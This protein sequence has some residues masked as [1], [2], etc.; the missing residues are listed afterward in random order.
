MGSESKFKAVPFDLG[1]TLVK[2]ADISEIFR[3]ILEIYGVRASI[4]DI[5]KA[6]QKNE[7]EL[8]VK[9]MVESGSG[10]WIKWNQKMLKRLRVQGDVEFL[11][12]QIDALWWDHADLEVYPEVSETLVQLERKEV[13]SGIVTNSFEKDFQ[14]ILQKLGL[15]DHF[16]VVVGIDTCKSAK[17]DREIFL[18]AVN[19]LDVR[20]EEAL[21]VGDSIQYDSEGA[22]A[23][24]LKP[25]LVDRNNKAIM[26]AQT[27]RSLAEVLAYV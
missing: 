24:G 3:R 13:K 16:D 2:T 21:F 6:Y 7:R 20:P 10:Y 12:T 5:S 14:S 9:D 8:G 4:K 25:L 19:K 22:K 17:P 15:A 1:G 23:A 18:F 11:A 27:I 26:S